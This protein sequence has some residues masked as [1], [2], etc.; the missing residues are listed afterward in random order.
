[1]Q[2]QGVN[3]LTLA[4]AVLTNEIQRICPRQLSITRARFGIPAVRQPAERNTDQ[5]IAL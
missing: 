1:V 3:G 5:A 4:K 2:H